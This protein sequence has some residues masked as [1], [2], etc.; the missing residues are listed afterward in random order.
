MEK[1]KDQRSKVESDMVKVSSEN[2]MLLARMK[3]ENIRKM[4]FYQEGLEREEQFK[5]EKDELKKEKELVTQKYRLLRK[6]LAEASNGNTT[7]P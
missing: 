4:E 2:D 5:K 7:N 1:E 3:E 6:H